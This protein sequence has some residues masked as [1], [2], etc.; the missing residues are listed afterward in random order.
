[1]DKLILKEI[2][3]RWCKGILLANEP[4]CSF[5]ADGE[6]LT[7]EEINYI[8]DECNKIAERITK[9]NHAINTTELVNEY[10]DC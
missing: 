7:P 5:N 3:K 6:Q 8:E 2:A 9:L 4:T 1:M 10:Y